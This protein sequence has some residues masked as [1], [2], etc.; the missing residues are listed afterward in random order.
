MYTSIS[1][2]KLLNRFIFTLH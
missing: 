1:N 2:E